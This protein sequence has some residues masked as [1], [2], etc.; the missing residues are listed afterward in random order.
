[1]RRFSHIFDQFAGSASGQVLLRRMEKGGVFSA[2]GVSGAAQSFLSAFLKH[3]FAERTLLVVAPNI[4][5]QER[6]HQ[7]LG[8]WLR[9]GSLSAPLSFFPEWEV[10]P[11]E[12]RLPHGGIIRE[13]LQTLDSL[14]H[15]PIIC[16]TAPSLAQRTLSASL[17]KNRVRTLAKGE[18][19]VMEELLEW[20]VAQGYARF[21]Q[22]GQRGEMARRGG[23]V[24]VFPYTSS[25]AFRL[26]FFGDVVESIRTFDPATQLSI[27][28]VEQV[29][30]SPGGEVGLLSGEPA[31][32]KS[33]LLDHL[34]KDTIVVLCEEDEISLALQDYF[35]RVPA[36]DSYHCQ[37]EVIEGWLRSENR[38]VAGLSELALESSLSDGEDSRM[39]CELDLRTLDLAVGEKLA[40]TLAPAAD[41]RRQ[42]LFNLIHRWWRQGEQVWVLCNNDGE[43]QRF[44]EIWA[45]FGF[46]KPGDEMRVELGTL[47]GGF[48]CPTARMVVVT[49]AEIFGRYKTRQPR[50]IRQAEEARRWVAPVAYTELEEGDFVVHV[51]H[52]IGQYTGM[53]VLSVGDSPQGEECLVIEYAPSGPEMAAPKLFVPVSEAHLVSKYIGAGRARPVL[54]AL[55]GRRW[56]KTK[57]RAEQSVRDLAAELLVIQAARASQEGHSFGADSPWQREFEAAFLYDETP[58]QQTAIDETKQ[59]LEARRPMDRLICGDVGFGKTEVAIRAAFK[60]V[61]GG[62]Q[63]AV[64]VPTTVL[65]HQHFNTFRERMADY[66]VRVEVLSRFRKASEQRRVMAA[67][68]NGGV[69]IVIGTHKLLSPDICFKDLGLVVVDEEQ[70][71]GVGHKE[72]FKLLRRMVDVLTLSATPIPRTLYLALVGARDMSVIQTPPMDRLPVETIVAE[73][74]ERLIRDAIDRE[75]NR[76]GQV[77]FLHNRVATING[78]GER[79]RRLVPKARIAVGHGQMESGELEEVM[80]RFVNG[81]VD[82]L[83]STTIIESGIDIPNAN[84]IIIDRAD[85]FGL[86]DLYQLRGRVGR[87]RHQAYAYI[88]LP[89]HM[90]LLREARKRI[91]ALKQHSAPGSGFKIALRDLE[92]RG[93]GNLLGVEQSGHITAI[94]FDLYCQ[95]LQ[96]SV[97]QLKGE[98]VLPRL[99]VRTQ[100]DFLTLGPN[101]PQ[102]VRSKT[103]SSRNSSEMRRDDGVVVWVDDE[104]V[105]EPES[106]NTCSPGAA[107]LPM[108]FIGDSRTRIELYRRLAQF[109]EASAIA[110]LKAELRDRFGKIPPA[111]NLLFQVADLKL[112]GREKQITLIEVESDRLKLFRN[113][114]WVIVDGRFPRLTARTP[115]SRLNE[116]QAL[117]RKI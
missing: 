87:Y 67:L 104:F 18:P 9:L 28:T 42:E 8:T 82:V 45:E 51:Q 102:V 79:L 33:T 107:Y 111:V 5:A 73:F 35:A 69:D 89:R 96:Q 47:G 3:T 99:E 116:M 117:L 49:D 68:E 12:A 95:L 53:E 10:L 59:D 58:D 76:G 75:L 52:G 94:G 71:F 100:F 43:R 55:G 2:S 60:A 83:L 101:P 39:D 16:A 31:E 108:D 112:L 30:L 62:K 103:P 19:V 57:E 63:V 56:A 41:I 113:G 7:D 91:S 64:L 85:R 54:N 92:I 13:R 97:R 24:D 26:E 22:V 66:P 44:L 65:A 27:D 32:A 1:M 36:G 81:E 4:K 106:V 61:M 88:L 23:I 25:L 114:D 84:T 40:G 93:A 70:R 15:S 37:I 50:R 14:A 17:L 90:A 105:S 110:E 86:S 74:D 6:L 115:A 78:V 80:M 98:K 46:Q 29:V 20:L 48:I 11:H 38:V 34:P 77:F 21:P 72:R 109:Q